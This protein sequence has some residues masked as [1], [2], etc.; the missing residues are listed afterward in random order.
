[1]LRNFFLG[2]S[3]ILSLGILLTTYI[4]EKNLNLSKLV[5]TFGHSCVRMELFGKRLL[6]RQ[7]RSARGVSKDRAP[8]GSKESKTKGQ[9][10]RK[11]I[12]RK[13][14]REKKEEIGSEKKDNGAGGCD[15]ADLYHRRRGIRKDAVG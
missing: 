7:L 3:E 2:R 11:E 14:E 5:M 12:K 1:M 8:S 4:S 9:N 13:N 6:Y 10:K 15:T